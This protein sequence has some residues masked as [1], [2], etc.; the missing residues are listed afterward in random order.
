[1]DISEL[2]NIAET[3]GFSIHSNHNGNIVEVYFEDYPNFWD[4]NYITSN[5]LVNVLFGKIVVYTSLKKDKESGKY[6]LT[7]RKTYDLK[8]YPAN[9]LYK[10]INRIS[11]TIK[12]ELIQFKLSNIEKDF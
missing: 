2:K 5:E 8:D 7:R 9:E 12:N 1:M 4:K 3:Y 11:K 10:T 6:V